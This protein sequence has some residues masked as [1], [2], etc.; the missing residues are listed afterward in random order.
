MALRDDY[1]TEAEAAR[2]LGVSGRTLRRWYSERIG[3]PRTKIGAKT[4][5]RKTG[6][7][8]W[9]ASRETTP[10]REQIAQGGEHA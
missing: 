3:P 7:A 8:A 5:Y 9:V 4:W 1:W 10:V 6:V 2:E